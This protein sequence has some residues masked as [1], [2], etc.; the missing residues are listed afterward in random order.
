ML[1]SV[2]VLLTRNP[3]TLRPL[4][5]FETAYLQYRDT[6]ALKA[7]N[8][9]QFSHDHFFKKGSILQQKWLALHNS[10]AH[11]SPASPSISSKQVEDEFIAAVA[12]INETVEKFSAKDADVKS[13]DRKLADPVFLVVK[14]KSTGKWSLPGSFQQIKQGE[15]L[16]EAA[17][18]SI[19]ESCGTKMETW[20]VGKIPIGHV[21]KSEKDK[22]FIMKQLI[23]SGQVDLN[24]SV[25][26]EH[27]WLTKEEM[28]EKLGKEDFEAIQ[29][30]I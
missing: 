13:L 1:P 30:V 27:A 14:S 20:A 19:E 4:S 15:L 25:V 2:A 24:P 8:T 23:L 9:K 21:A 22:T 12:A 29:D 18:R 10:L 26:S 3:V 7:S 6:L 5:A 11:S 28:K 16:H 17:K